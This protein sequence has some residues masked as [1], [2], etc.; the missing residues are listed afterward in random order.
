MS[1]SAI[2]VRTAEIR[3]EPAQPNLFEKK[4]NILPPASRETWSRLRPSPVR[5]TVAG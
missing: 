1:A 3:I 4:K 2:R 5:P